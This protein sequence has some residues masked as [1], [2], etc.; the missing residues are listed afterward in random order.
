M[1]RTS[2]LITVDRGELRAGVRARVSEG[3]RVADLIADRAGSLRLAGLGSAGLG[4]AK[5]GRMRDL[6]GA[7]VYRRV[8]SSEN[9]LASSRRLAGLDSVKIGQ[10]RG[11]VRVGAS[12]QE[13]GLAG[14]RHLA[15]PHMAK[16]GPMHAVAGVL[17]SGRV[18]SR[19]LAGPG[20]TRIGPMPGLV[21]AE[22][23]GLEND[24]AGLDLARA[25]AVR[26]VRA[27]TSYRLS[28]QLV[29]GR[30]SI[31][32]RW[33]RRVNV[34]ARAMRACP[35]GV[36]TGRNGTRAEITG[37]RV[38]DR[39]AVPGSVRLVSVAGNLSVREAGAET[40]LVGLAKAVRG[41]AGSRLAR[42]PRVDQQA[43]QE[44]GLSVDRALNP[45]FDLATGRL[46]RAI[47]HRTG[48]IA[49]LLADL[50][51]NQLLNRGLNRVESRASSQVREQ[52]L[53]LAG[54]RS[55]AVRVAASN[56]VQGR[57]SNPVDRAGTGTVAG[58]RA[59]NPIWTHKKLL[60]G[61]DAS[62]AL[63]LHLPLFPA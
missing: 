49:D 32:K 20:S 62:G 24:R 28:G 40:V 6:K 41:A 54:D 48:Q 21:A 10:M 29:A 45:I 53:V 2:G 13:N 43:D 36:R 55:R 47:F 63:R 7:Q 9:G 17:G 34:P 56:R 19:R 51:A 59:S 57:V 46:S 15:G 31:L 14:D 8:S 60:L 11:L 3:M 50:P 5:T 39:I 23:N 61:L 37:A 26:A 25:L 33:V 4:S 38:A 16:I 35:K 22:A 30:P 42:D 27:L 52:A 44:T 58:E 1:V 18:G 12:G